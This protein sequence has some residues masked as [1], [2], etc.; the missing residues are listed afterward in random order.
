PVYCCCC[1]QPPQYSARP[2]T[3]SKGCVGIHSDE[4]NS[5]YISCDCSGSCVVS[6]TLGI[7][8]CAG[9]GRQKHR[10]E[11]QKHRAE[12]CCCESR[13]T[14]DEGPRRTGPADQIRRPQY[15]GGAEPAG[16]KTGVPVRDTSRD[17][18]CVGQRR[19][20]APRCRATPDRRS[21]RCALHL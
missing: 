5:A 1:Q 18:R 4:K 16:G 12:R 14:A 20:A 2:E 3:T 8:C 21:A 7:T 11:R 13:P 17:L 6:G 9:A 10:T 19:P 15:C